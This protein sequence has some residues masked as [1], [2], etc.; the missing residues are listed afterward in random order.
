MDVQT[1]AAVSRPKALYRRPA[2]LSNGLPPITSFMGG[3]PASIEKRVLDTIQAIVSLARIGHIVSMQYKIR[4]QPEEWAC[5]KFCRIPLDDDSVA[6]FILWL[7][8]NS[9]EQVGTRIAAHSKNEVVWYDPVES[10][11]GFDA[12]RQR[13]AKLLWRALHGN[14]SDEDFRRRFSFP[15]PLR[16]SG[17]AQ[18]L[19]PIQ[20]RLK[21]IMEGLFRRS[22]E[23]NRLGQGDWGERWWLP[24]EQSEFVREQLKL[25]HA[26]LIEHSSDYEEAVSLSLSYHVRY[27]VQAIDVPSPDPARVYVGER[28]GPYGRVFVWVR[29]TDGNKYPLK[30][31]DQPYR[32]ADGTGFE[33]GYGG[34]G[35]GVL[36]T[37]ILADALDGDL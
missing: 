6:E 15:T 1:V 10:A 31:S 7:C 33:W 34:H 22:D 9:R 20:E 24:A 2:D 26:E 30:H 23:D 16:T 18:L 14:A 37:C 29:D 4:T 8:D 21:W 13:M 25:T 17:C 36:T 35:P 11:W 3:N 5:T 19:S 12:P 28:H 27:N 32:E